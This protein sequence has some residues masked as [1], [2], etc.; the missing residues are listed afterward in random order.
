MTVSMYQISLPAFVRHLNGLV[1][2]LKK[3]RTLYAEKK[4]D[5]STLL[6]YRLYPDMFSFTRQVQ[7]A[8]DHAKNCAALLAGLE[9][10]KYED[11]EKSLA[12]L[13]ARVGKTI[14]WLN[15]I[16]PEQIDGTEG[17]SVTVKMR[18]RETKYTGLEL[19]LNRSLPNFYFHATTAYDII[20]HN[21]VEV[22]KRDFMGAS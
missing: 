9:A 14:A 8:S 21:G 15:T 10:P 5:E 17:K 22:G 2:V 6:S 3:A 7:A 16:K 4:Y 11:N 1:T 20:R 12:E 13:I 18:D 19:L